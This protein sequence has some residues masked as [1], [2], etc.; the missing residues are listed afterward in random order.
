MFIHDDDYLD[1]KYVVSNSDNYIVLTN[2]R[3]VYADYTS[4]EDIACLVQYLEPSD[5]YFTTTQTFYQN[6]TFP[7]IEVDN[8]MWSRADISNI[9]FC[10]ALI[11]CLTL[12]IYG[13]VSRIFVRGGLNR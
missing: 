3:R 4:P 5:L 8:D 7:S 13:I 2:V 6:R 10:S 9:L 1:Y 11:V 12:F